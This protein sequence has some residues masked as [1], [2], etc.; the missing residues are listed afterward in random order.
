[1]ANLDVLGSMPTIAALGVL[2]A[3]ALCDIGFRTLPD[4]FSAVL[5][6]CGGVVHFATGDLGPAMFATMA[7]AAAATL[8]WRAG[9]LGGG[10]VK[11]LAATTLVVPLACIPTLLL[12]TALAGGVLALGFIALRPFVPAVAPPRPS[13]L[14]A[15]VLRAEAWRIRRGGPLPYAV[16][17][18][19][20]GAVS[21]LNG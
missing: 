6:V 16:A 17:I 19:V 13:G 11:L 3:A 8:A 9:A 4:T 20:G 7:V 14:L 15:R 1:M 2:A 5:L 18:A 10:D 12:G 21:L